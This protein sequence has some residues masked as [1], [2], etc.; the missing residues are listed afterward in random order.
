MRSASGLGWMHSDERFS[1]VAFA[2]GSIRGAAPPASGSGGGA[3]IVHPDA[4]AVSSRQT[5]NRSIEHLRTRRVRA[6]ANIIPTVVH[7]PLVNRLM[8]CL[9]TPPL[10]ARISGAHEGGVPRWERCV[11]AARSVRS[12]GTSAVQPT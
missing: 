1:L 8:L 10:P 4:I 9:S 12:R 3:P 2:H 6:G 7:E 11:T 5:A